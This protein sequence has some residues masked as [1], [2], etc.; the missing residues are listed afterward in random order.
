MFQGKAGIS[1]VGLCLLTACIAVSPLPVFNQESRSLPKASDLLANPGL[2]GTWSERMLDDDRKIR[3]RAAA[4]L[5]QGGVESLPLLRRVL[6]RSN[7][8]DLVAGHEEEFG[9][10][11]D[12][13]LDQ[14]GTGDAIDM[15]M[16]PGYPAHCGLLPRRRNATGSIVESTGSRR[17]NKSA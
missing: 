7:V 13:T 12:E 9:I 17:G 3:E 15:D 14:P 2:I 10:G 16:G 6:L 11:I 5:V 1:R 4:E 8:I